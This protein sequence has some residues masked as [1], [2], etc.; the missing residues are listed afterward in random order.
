MVPQ[1][2]RLDASMVDVLERMLWRE[3]GDGWAVR[4][5][6]GRGGGGSTA[7]R[8]AGQEKAR[9]IRQPDAGSAELKLLCFQASRLAA[10]Q[11][12]MHQGD[13]LSQ[14]CRQHLHNPARLC[15]PLEQEDA[16]GIHLDIASEGRQLA[17][18]PC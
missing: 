18:E 12:P 13:P 5:S 15:D 4:Q 17:Y 7:L 3:P 9:E 11:I 2:R 10:L 16:Q 14:G 6:P 8:M 1:I